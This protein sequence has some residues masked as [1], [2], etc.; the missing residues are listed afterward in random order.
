M[1][2]NKKILRL[3]VPSI[4]SNLTVPL[5]GLIDVG[6]V[7]HLGSASYIGALAIG[8]ML[9][10]MIYWGFGFLRM[11]TS[12]MTAQAYGKQDTAEISDTLA[13]AVLVGFGI[14]ALLL[15]LQY[16]VSRA[17]FYL[18]RPGEEVEAGASL[19]FAVC[20]WGAPAVLGLYGFTGWF[21]GLQNTRFPMYI[22]F[23]QYALNL[24]FSLAFVFLLHMKIAGV[25][26]GTLVAQWG[27]FLMAVY[28]AS[29]R[30]KQFRP[31]IRLKALFRLPAM[32]RF[33][34]VNSDIFLR[35]LCLIAVTT[36]FTGAGARQGDTILAV[37][38]L[39]IQLFTLFSY[40]MDSFA[41]AG[42]ALAGRY[43]GERN[44]P[45]LKQTVKHLF[46][47][48]SGVAVLFTL[49]YGV[50]G[51]NFLRLLTDNTAV[52]TAASR[53]FYWALAI[54]LAGFGAFLWD[55]IFIG[56]TTTR[57]ML[58]AMLLAS[59]VFFA[60]YYGLKGALGNDALWLAFLVYLAL[61]GI[62]SHIAS[63]AVYRTIDC[64]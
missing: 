15:L 48:G 41:Y 35:T 34:S 38:T 24:V 8:G 54:P 26:A 60:L 44:L 23:V 17:A 16:P 46:Y 31:V 3:A 40:F 49:L 50:G 30:Y 21:V 32:R 47:W 39:L 25:A 43:V 63:G 10:N 18:L 64:R 45:M 33:F 2:L 53:Y 29:R 27:G 4:V 22:A 56:A 6:I 59:A 13:R 5:L 62:V 58:Y 11:G 14:A 51:E 1:N 12:G 36:F 28:L 52:L 57:I 61:R 7:G 19:Y 55:G 20:I 37:N 9:F 42:E